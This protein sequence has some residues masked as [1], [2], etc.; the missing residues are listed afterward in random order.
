MS[1][2]TTNFGACTC[3]KNVKNPISLAR[4]ICDKQSSLFQFGRIPPILVSGRLKDIKLNE[5]GS[6]YFIF[7][8]VGSGASELAKELGLT[9]VN[10]ND[11]I[12]KKAQNT[13][14]YYRRKI[15]EFETSNSVQLSAL[16]TVGKF[17][18]N[19]LLIVSV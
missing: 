1:S 5:L 7:L 3:V 16:D 17:F 15:V 6:S 2:I 19:D 8:F 10:E 9:I 18:M 4:K 12:S 13:F 11:L 14:N